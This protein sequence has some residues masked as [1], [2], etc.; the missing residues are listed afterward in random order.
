MEQE[1]AEEAA[2]IVARAAVRDWMT[3]K[4]ISNLG[5][6]SLD[7][8]LSALLRNNAPHDAE[9]DKVL[10]QTADWY[11]EYLNGG[12][13]SDSR[14]LEFAGAISMHMEKQTADGAVSA[15]AYL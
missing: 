4:G 14:L 12:L 15:E 11:K 2:Q 5:M 8:M 7:E 9:L 1:I 6:V 3:R 10:K 13:V